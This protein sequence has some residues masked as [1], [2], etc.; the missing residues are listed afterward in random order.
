MTSRPPSFLI[1]T[2]P[3]P[4]AILPLEKVESASEL[5]SHCNYRET[6]LTE[7]IPPTPL[8]HTYD[9]QFWQR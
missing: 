3:Y 6:I 5:S 4:F 2:T 1:H 7:K 8:L 9:L